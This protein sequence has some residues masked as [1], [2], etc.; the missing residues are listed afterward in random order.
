MMMIWALGRDGWESGTAGE[1]DRRDSRIMGRREVGQRGSGT[2]GEWDRRGCWIK[3]QTGQ[4]HS[5]IAGQEGQRDR[6][7]K[8]DS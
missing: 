4:R 6:R 5:G 7:D 1:W 8:W 2:V 3:E